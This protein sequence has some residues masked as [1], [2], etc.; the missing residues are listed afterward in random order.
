M[1]LKLDRS[2]LD[3][4]RSFKKGAMSLNLVRKA[5]CGKDRFVS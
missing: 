4:P 2:V 1:G 3:K 5:I